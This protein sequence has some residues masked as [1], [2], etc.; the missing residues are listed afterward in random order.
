MPCDDGVAVFFSIFALSGPE[1]HPARG[2]ATFRPCRPSWC[3]FSI[4]LPAFAPL[5]LA[6]TILNTSLV[7]LG[8]WLAGRIYRVGILS[9]RRRLRELFRWIRTA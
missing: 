6:S 4:P 1:L 9:P 5:Q 2:S 7:F 8:V 3:R